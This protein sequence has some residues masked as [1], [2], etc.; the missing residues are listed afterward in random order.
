MRRAV[1]SQLK[2][3]ETTGGCLPNLVVLADPTTEEGEIA[4]Q[5]AL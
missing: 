1:K 3:G 4:A 5:R 2:S